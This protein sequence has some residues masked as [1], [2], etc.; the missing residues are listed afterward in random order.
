[1][2]QVAPCFVLSIQTPYFFHH[3][4]H[5]VDSMKVVSILDQK[6]SDCVWPSLHWRCNFN[7]Q[8]ICFIIF[9]FHLD[10]E[11]RVL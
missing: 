10:K 11:K 4:A 8:E 2:P 5:A 6:N 1:M 9:L 3:T 7:S